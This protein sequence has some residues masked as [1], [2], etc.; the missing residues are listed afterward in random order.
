MTVIRLLLLILVSA[1]TLAPSAHAQK[2]TCGAYTEAAESIASGKGKIPEFLIPGSAHGNAYIEGLGRKQF[3]DLSTLYRNF[4]Q[5]NPLLSDWF[6]PL[7]A[8]MCIRKGEM[9]N[10][11]DNIGMVIQEC[12]VSPKNKNEFEDR[13]QCLMES[14]IV[15]SAELANLVAEKSNALVH[16]SK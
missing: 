9:G 12:N 15:T 7:V 14:E 1:A 11:F 4:I 2:I 3:Q 10:A 5:R 8:A 16:A 13:M 6:A